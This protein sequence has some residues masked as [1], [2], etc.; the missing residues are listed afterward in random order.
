ME[1]VE[2]RQ[3]RAPAARARREVRWPVAQRRQRRARRAWLHGG[4]PRAARAAP[5][6]TW[7]TIRCR[8]TA[9]GSACRRWP[10]CTTWRSSPPAAATG[11]RGGCMA[12]APTAAPATLRAPWSASLAGDGDRGGGAARAATA[13]RLV[14]APPRPRPAPTRPH[15]G[16]P[17]NGGPLLFVGDGEPRKNLDGLLA[18]LRRLPRG[19]GR[20]RAAGAGRAG[21]RGG[22]RRSPA[23][24]PAGARAAASCSICTARP[25]ALVHPSLHEGFG[26]TLLEAMARGVPVL[27]VRNAGTEGG[28]RGRRAARGSGRAGRRACADRRRRRTCAPAWPRG[29]ASG[30]APS[31]GPERHAITSA[32]I[33]WPA[34]AGPPTRAGLHE[35]RHPRHPRDP[36]RPTAASRP[37]WSRSPAASPPAGTG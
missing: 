9:A 2:A 17:R 35:R 15:R 31:R 18:G 7:C 22:G 1:V 26:L 14:V 10:R 3:R 19:R 34:V 24:R 4:L 28:V 32:P 13:A 36:R 23:C 6:P 27:A 8:P 33:R 37:P 25:A 29:A 30:R 16:Q 20:P 21:R 5:A 12:A 11:E